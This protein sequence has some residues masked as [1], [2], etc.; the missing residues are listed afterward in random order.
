MCIQH[1][2]T[3]LIIIYSMFITTISATVLDSR[4]DK[5]LQKGQG[6]RANRPRLSQRLKNEKSLIQCLLAVVHHSAEAQNA[7]T[8]YNY[9]NKPEK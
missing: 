4:Q 9:T 8:Q 5:S 2:V 6:S 3:N 7:P 1:E